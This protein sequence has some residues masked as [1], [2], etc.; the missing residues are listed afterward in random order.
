MLV[1][2]LSFVIVILDQFTKYLI[3]S[4]VSRIDPIEVVPGFFNIAHVRNTGA[5]WG[6]FAGFGDGLIV[7]SVVML[8]IIIV[9]RRHFIGDR[10]LDRTA[11]AFMIAGIIGNLIDRVKLGYVV[12]FLDFHVGASHFPS[13]NV[14]DSAIC[15]GVCLY[16]IAHFLE[17]LA[18]TQVCK[19]A[20]TS[21]E[22]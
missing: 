21:G 6:M 19:A 2:C 12:D 10:F 11:M 20:E 14:A 3:L 5:A 22:E 17:T 13:F 8:F 9:F 7:L 15:V 4:G 16:L 18:R 1:L